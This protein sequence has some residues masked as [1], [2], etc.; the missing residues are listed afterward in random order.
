[1]DLRVGGKWR[2]EIRMP[3]PYHGVEVIR[4]DGYVLEFDPPHLL[5]DTWFAYFHTDPQHRSIVRWE[6]IPTKWG[7]HVK[8]THNGLAAEPQARKDFADR[9]PGVLEEIRE[10]AEQ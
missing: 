3:K 6:L 8:V 4:H 7:T 5:A 10:W 1:M 9:S 2:L